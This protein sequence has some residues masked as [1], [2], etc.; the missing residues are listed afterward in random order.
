MRDGLFE[1]PSCRGYWKV[2]RRQ[3]A[4]ELRRAQLLVVEEDGGMGDA[5][6]THPGR[7][8]VSHVVDGLGL[9]ALVESV[10]PDERHSAAL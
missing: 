8:P 5:A 4:D 10:E 1:Q 2:P 6:A 9:R 7:G 3:L